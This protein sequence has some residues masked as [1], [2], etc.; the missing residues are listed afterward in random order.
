MSFINSAAPP[1]HEQHVRPVLAILRFYRVAE[2]YG[3][4]GA[5]GSALSD[6]GMST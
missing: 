2:E 5:A 6:E 4:D 3:W 1:R